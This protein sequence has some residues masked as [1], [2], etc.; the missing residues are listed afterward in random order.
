MEALSN[1]WF[2]GKRGMYENMLRQFHAMM[3]VEIEKMVFVPGETISV[4]V[5]G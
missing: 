3:L 4:D 2:D 5:N 1:R